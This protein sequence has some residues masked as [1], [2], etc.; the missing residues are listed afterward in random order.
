[1]TAADKKQINLNKEF[2]TKRNSL[3]LVRL[4]LALLVIVSHAFILGG[5]GK[6]PKVLGV[7]L[8]S[9][10]VAGFFCISG[11]LIAS[12]R[13]HTNLGNYLVKRIARI[14]PAF[15]VI[16]VLVVILFAPLA[17]LIN[18]GSLKGYMSEEPTP[19]S[20]LLKNLTLSLWQ[21]HYGIG[22]TLVDTPVVHT[23]NGPLYTLFYEFSCYLIVGLLL[24]WV[25]TRNK[26]AIGIIWAAGVIG[27][28]TFSRFILW[29]PSSQPI[30]GHNVFQIM[31]RLVPIFLGGTLVY[32]IQEKVKKLYWI[33]ALICALVCIAYLVL[34]PEMNE[35]K[36]G[37][38]APFA[39]YFLLWFS[40]SCTFGKLGKLTSENDIS[41]GVYI[42]GWVFQQ[43]I[44]V[45]VINHYIPQPPIWLYIITTIELTVIFATLSWIFV[46]H[47]ILQR[48]RHPRN[49]KKFDIVTPN[50]LAEGLAK[51]EP[52][53]ELDENLKN[54]LDKYTSDK[55]SGGEKNGKTAPSSS[56][57]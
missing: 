26:W 34:V 36:L 15:L 6:P 54:L 28:F 18:D 44:M 27:Q 13:M 10:A 21:D 51:V 42:Y 19:L 8:G 30:T 40:N 5:Y 41:Y 29:D 43:I 23:W 52:I 24:S 17:K 4:F 1:M 25:V 57:K 14:Y 9:W 31:V 7:D 37:F 11:Y 20:Y 48:V 50:S 32:L 53:V 3:N 47:P 55:K 33:V 35:N 16:Q 46:E 22:K 39:T 56:R 45:F 38:I 49:T 12:S 2:N